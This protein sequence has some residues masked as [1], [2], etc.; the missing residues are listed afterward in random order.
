MNIDPAITSNITLTFHKIQVHQ[1]MAQIWD[2][3]F[4]LIKKK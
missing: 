2:D 3:L 4:F 1:T